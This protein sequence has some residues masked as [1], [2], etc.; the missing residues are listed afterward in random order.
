VAAVS[1]QG[2]GRVLG[3]LPTFPLCAS[4]MHTHEPLT[5]YITADL[6]AGTLAAR[7]DNR[8]VEKPPA[9]AA[10]G[11]RFLTSPVAVGTSSRPTSGPRTPPRPPAPDRSTAR[12]RPVSPAAAM[13]RRPRPDPRYTP[14]QSRRSRRSRDRRRP[15]PCSPLQSTAS[16]ASGG[17]RRRGPAGL[18]PNVVEGEHIAA[19]VSRIPVAVTR[20]QALHG[21][22]HG[23]QRL[24]PAP[25]GHIARVVG[26]LCQ[27][28]AAAGVGAREPSRTHATSRRR[29][30]W[31]PHA[32]R[33]KA[34]MSVSQMTIG[35]PPGR[36]QT[37]RD[38]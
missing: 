31:N 29:G 8:G 13:P 2:V 37:G 33:D 27:K 23:G 18:D 10:E 19:G 16:S 7:R 6:A 25:G 32:D 36:R 9:N 4:C 35:S 34:A 38:R 12:S 17:H 26:I 14:R 3:R 28:D 30:C 5:D 24:G 11:Q 15:I 1:R 22:P 20:T 21:L